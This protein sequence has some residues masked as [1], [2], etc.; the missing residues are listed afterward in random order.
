MLLQLIRVPYDT[1]TPLLSA[2]AQCHRIKTMR[3]H[4]LLGMSQQ[5]QAKTAANAAEMLQAPLAAVGPRPTPSTAVT[6]CLAIMFR[7]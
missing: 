5:H 3:Y 1:N 6:G 7:V 2:A 4:K